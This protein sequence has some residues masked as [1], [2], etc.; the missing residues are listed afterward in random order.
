M[1]LLNPNDLITNKT[2]PISANA[3]A[4]ELKASI[5]DHY[6]YNPYILSDIET[7]RTWY[8]ANGT[9]TTNY[10]ETMMSVYHI[11]VKKLQAT[12]TASSITTI[13]TTSKAT[14]TVDIPADV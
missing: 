6:Y 12:P 7:N 8:D 14:I 4:E 13:K 1:L 5:K 11:I 9:E 10:T 2:L 3:T